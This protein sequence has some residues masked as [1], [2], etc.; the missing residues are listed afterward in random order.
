[1]LSQIEVAKHLLKINAIKLKPHQPFRWASGLQSPIYC[2]NRKILSHPG[3]RKDI[4]V[5]L[6]ELSSGFGNVEAISGVATAGIAHGMMVA[7]LLD[8]PFSYVRSSPKSHGA[9]NQV[10]GEIPK[11]LNCV[12]I[13]DL[14]STGGSSLQAV[15]LLRNEG[16]QV[17]GVAA[18]FS[19]Q[20]SQAEK[21]FTDANCRFNSLSNYEALMEAANEENLFSEAEMDSL[22]YWKKNPEAWSQQFD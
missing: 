12:V 9:G 14:I 19:Y 11:G 15:E 22:R 10:E 8:L 7:S 18:I 6:S 21:R 17:L 3:V 13:E 5:A 16:V 20:F 4:H 2:D 1:M